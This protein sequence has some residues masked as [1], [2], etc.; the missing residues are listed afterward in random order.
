MTVAR[1]P[2]IESV[3]HRKLSCQE[4]VRC[5][6]RFVAVDKQRVKKGMEGLEQAL[7]RDPEAKKE[8]EREQKEF[9]ALV[10]AEKKRR[11]EEHRTTTSSRTDG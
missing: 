1:S 9:E 7:K 11:D 4:E 8:H 6:A 3:V 2:P 5:M 10:A